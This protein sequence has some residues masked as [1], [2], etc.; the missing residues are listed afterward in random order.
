M[1]MQKKMDHN[2]KTRNIYQ[3]QHELISADRAA[4][5]R[6]SDMYKNTTFGLDAS[7]FEGKSALDAGCG[8]IGS[9]II[10]LHRLGAC[11]VAGTDIG[12][13]W[14]GSLTKNLVTA[15]IPESAYSLK[16]GNLLNLPY[17]DDFFDFVA[18]NGVLIHL[19]TMDDVVKG[20]AQGAGKTKQGGYYYTSYGPCGGVMQGVIMP[21]LREHYRKDLEF[22]NLIDN[23]SPDTIHTTI[24]KIVVDAKMFANHDLD[25]DFLKSLF[26]WDYCVFL[27][28]FIQAP[29]WWSNECTPLFVEALY[30]DNG[31]TD[32]KRLQSYITRNDI[33][34]Y[35][36]PLHYDREHPISRI[37]YGEGYVQY[38]GRK[39]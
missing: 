6:I 39:C 17:P 32:V 4:F 22:K 8:N 36:A 33:R 9:L 3:A 13:E 27:Q 7:W 20:F 25:A 18:I 16:E 11:M 31:F 10:K 29:T 37:L 1:E 23:I 12:T 38:I 19:E 24:D 5:S 14:I 2:I 28:N 34:K 26:G 21:A 35:F 15:G 30:R